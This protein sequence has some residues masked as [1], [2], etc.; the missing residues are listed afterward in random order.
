[1]ASSAFSSEETGL[2]QQLT[3]LLTMVK[4]KKKIELAATGFLQLEAAIV[5]LIA[6]RLKQ[7]AALQRGIG[8][9]DLPQGLPHSDYVSIDSGCI[10]AG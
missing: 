8:F 6:H 3:C 5:L 4:I 7:W 1:M 2:Q 9:E 10:P